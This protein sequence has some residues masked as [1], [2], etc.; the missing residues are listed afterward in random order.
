MRWIFLSKTKL[1]LATKDWRGIASEN[2]IYEQKNVE[3]IT[4]EICP[5]KIWLGNYSIC[6][7]EVP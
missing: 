3:I 4:E 7:A 5:L 6:M 1:V 2:I